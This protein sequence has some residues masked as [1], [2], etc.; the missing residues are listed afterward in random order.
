MI[1]SISVL[2]LTFPR[3]LKLAF[4]AYEYIDQLIDSFLLGSPYS[5]TFDQ[6]MY[7]SS[8]VNRAR[9]IRSP[10]FCIHSN[11]GSLD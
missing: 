5:A 4:F 6:R 8:I 2:Q 10:D 11:R 1:F 9:I 7:L 3:R